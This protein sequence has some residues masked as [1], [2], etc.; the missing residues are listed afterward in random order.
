VE[1]EGCGGKCE[2]E[3]YCCA[4]VSELFLLLDAWGEW[5]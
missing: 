4:R 2:E 1:G 3:G 5:G